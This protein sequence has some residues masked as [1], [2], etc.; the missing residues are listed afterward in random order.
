MHR[1]SAGDK[2]RLLLSPP[3]RPIWD[4]YVDTTLF[5]KDVLSKAAYD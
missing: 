1:A 4:K 5:M 3:L 2:A